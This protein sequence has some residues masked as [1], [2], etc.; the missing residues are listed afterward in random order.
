MSDHIMQQYILPSHGLSAGSLNS[1]RHAHVFEL[2][3][4]G[5]GAAQ[6]ALLREQ[7]SAAAL[8]LL[9]L[10]PYDHRRFAAGVPRYGRTRGVRLLL[11]HTLCRQKL[12]A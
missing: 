6:E 12:Q 1:K 2:G 8:Q 11:C 7:A 4:L 5:C 3:L 9:D 10:P